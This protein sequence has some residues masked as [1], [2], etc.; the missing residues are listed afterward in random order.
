MMFLLR[1]AFW[2]S[3]VLA[4]L[5]SF[6]PQQPP[7]VATD[8]NAAQAVTAASATVADLGEFCGRQ[9]DACT[10]G[11]QL[12]TAFGQRTEAGAKILYDLIGDRFARSGHAASPAGVT[13]DA[14]A[15]S[16]VKP[17]Q[18]TLTAADL[19]P[20]WRGVPLRREGAPRRS[21]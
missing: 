2:S 5:P 4:L 10:A 3:V 16:A 20:A 19:T 14:P 15:S 7:S 11:G 13:A 12:A 1:T 21:S 6:G 8:F 18:S 17:S 9:P